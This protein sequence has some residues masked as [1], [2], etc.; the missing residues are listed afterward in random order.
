MKRILLWVLPILVL[1]SI[2][3]AGGGRG[4]IGRDLDVA[5]ELTDD[6]IREITDSSSGRATVKFTDEQLEILVD[7]VPEFA[8][9]EVTLEPIHISRAGVVVLGLHVP[10]SIVDPRSDIEMDP[11]PSP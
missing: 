11:H 10:D 7:A 9:E 2:A 4:G 6:Q 8:F 5:I 3:M 1:A